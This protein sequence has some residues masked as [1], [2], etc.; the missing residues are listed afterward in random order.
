LKIRT[1][2]FRKKCDMALSGQTLITCQT[3]KGSEKNKLVFSGIEAR[4]RQGVKTKTYRYISSFYNASGRDGL[5][6]EKS[7][8]FFSEPLPEFDVDAIL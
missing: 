3:N 1:E 4:V 2:I 6:S 5:M 8:V 7:K